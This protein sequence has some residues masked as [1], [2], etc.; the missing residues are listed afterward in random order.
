MNEKTFIF[1]FMFKFITFLKI[2]Q[3]IHHEPTIQNKK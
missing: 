2:E 1:I 3:S